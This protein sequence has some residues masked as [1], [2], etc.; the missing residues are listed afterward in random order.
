M[1]K[2]RKKAIGCLA[3]TAAITASTIQMPLVAANAETT[4]TPVRYEAEKATLT[5]T[6]V[7][8]GTIFSNGAG[9]DGF[10]TAGD[11][12]TFNVN[13]E[14]AGRYN[15]TIGYATPYGQKNNTLV[16][17]G[18]V[19]SDC[20]F[21]ASDTVKQL[22]VN[23]ISLKAGANTIAIV[24]SW[25]WMQVDYIDV[26][27]G[28]ARGPLTPV[29]PNLVNPYASTS[30]KA[31]MKYL[32]DNYGSKIITGQQ[33][34]G[35]DEINYIY[36]L[37]GKLPAIQGFDILSG[38]ADIEKAK[39]WASY[40]GI[41]ELCW[42][43]RAPSGGSDFY[44]NGT[45]FD[46][47]KA[48]TPGTAE[49]AL[50]LK[51]IDATAAKLKVLQDAGIP[52][53]WRPLHEASGGWFWWGAKGAE[54]LKQ[55]YKI[56]FDKLTN[57]YKLNNLIWVWTSGTDASASTW[58]PGDAYADIIGVDNYPQTPD[59]GSFVNSFDTLVALGAKNKL[60]TMSE[61]GPIPDTD[62]LQADGA[63]WSYFST[64]SGK[65]IM[66]EKE[67]TSDLI[68]KVYTSDYALTLD[69]IP[70]ASIYGKA[71]LPVWAAKPLPT[72]AP[73]PEGYTVFE[74]EK[75]VLSGLTVDNSNKGYSGTGYVG[76]FGG[77]TDN[78]SLNVTVDKGGEYS[79][80]VRHSAPYGSKEYNVLVNGA[81]VATNKIQE[82]SLF[83]DSTAVTVKL[84]A[85]AN[86]IKI[87]RGWGWFNVDCLMLK[88]LNGQVIGGPTTQVI[89]E[90]Y[91][92]YE[93]ENATLTGVEV[94]N[95]TKGFSGTGYV[96]SITD[97][98]DK[99]DFKVN[100][101]EGGTYSLLVRHAAPYG[102]KAYN[103]LVNGTQA[104]TNN[105]TESTE[106]SNSAE[107]K[108]ELKAGDN[109]IT[110]DRGWG[111]YE[112]DAIM[113]KAL[114]TRPELTIPEGYTV[115]EAEK[116]TLNGTAVATAMQGFSG[117]GYVTSFEDDTD[118]LAMNVNV[119]AAGTYN[120]IVRHSAPYGA[121]EYN[122]LV[123][124]TAVATN[125][126]AESTYFSDTTPIEIKL[127]AGDNTITIDRGWGWFNVDLIMVKPVSVVTTYSLGDVNKD[128]KVNAIDLAFVKKAILNGTTDSMDLTVADMNKDGKINAIDLALLKKKLLS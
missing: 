21:P 78:L 112:L 45:T 6:E 96:T 48:V 100:V 26:Q 109:T 16:V 126:V 55:L 4:A 5:G 63:A 108:I 86:T 20:V 125:K 58:Y 13:V 65:F 93:A 22:T 88:P 59:H 114:S 98:T 101:K 68:K 94:G 83:T 51:D 90:G 60:V 25:G 66:D 67:N 46:I 32:T 122:V 62:N 87:D 71:P 43:W 80:I 82:S 116:G 121:K 24:N 75:A 72:A 81:V 115:Y 104:G 118:N 40:G 119:A 84:T 17:N 35:L 41:V 28:E 3:M 10:D 54:P 11:A 117:T 2:G 34:G 110:I 69:E 30:T 73:I 102:D 39:T 124:G 127:N 1:V 123:N 52:V 9:V 91:T 79:L 64:W 70:S 37:T 105:I 128:G 23:N 106:F 92:A 89:P 50:I 76:N 14:Q 57:E 97:D 99:V 103:V 19:I 85:G 53:L 61:N 77:A 29:Q 18:S 7:K 107:L 12:V 47:T 95:T 56:L 111:W 15:I 120:L 113:L 36:S 74:A 31:L 38:D 49:N 42:H 8:T 44:T 33:S 27:L